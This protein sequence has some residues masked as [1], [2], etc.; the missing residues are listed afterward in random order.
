M[1][2]LPTT[3]QEL[4]GVQP[5][6]VLISADAYVD[7]PSFGHALIA[8]LIESQG[9]TIGII[10]QPQKDSD[11]ARLGVPKHAF[12]ISGGVVDS[13][14]N[15]YTV[16]KQ[17]RKEDDYSEGGKAGMRPDRATTVYCQTLKR[18]YSDVPVIIGGIEASLR[19]FAHYD[20]WSD[21]VMP[22]ILVDSQADLLIYGMGERP[23]LDILALL[24]KG[25]DIVSIKDVRGTAYLADNLPKHIAEGVSQGK[26]TF[27][28]TL[29]EVRQNKRQY[30][31]AFNIQNNNSDSITAKIVVQR[32]GDKYVIQNLPQLPLTEQEMDMVYALPYQRTYH[33]MYKGGVPAIEEVK[34]SLTSV[35]GCFGRCS[36]CALTFHQGRLVQRRSQQSIIQE[37]KLLTQDQQ[38]KGYIHDVGGPTANFRQPACKKQTTV[39][40][41]QDKQCIGYQPC[42]GLEVSHSEYLQLL[43]ELRAL[44]KVK[45][46][47]IRSGIRFDYVML[48]NNDDFF[49]ELVEHHVS[50]QLKVAPEHTEDKVLKLMNKPSFEVYKKFKNKFDSYSAKLGK[51]QYLVPY[52]I[53][54][55]PGCTIKDAIKVAEYL[56]SIGYMP[57]QV[58]DFYPTPASKSTCMYYTGIDPDSGEEIFVPRT[59]QQKQLQRALLQY[60]KPQNYW[61]VR[62]A[63][64]EGGRRDLIGNRP[65][66]LIRDNPPTD[67]T[68]Y[69]N[70]TSTTRPKTSTAKSAYGSNQKLT[71]KP[72]NDNNKSAYGTPNHGKTACA[73]TSD[74]SKP[75][76]STAKSAYGSKPT[77]TTNKSTGHTHKGKDT[78]QTPAN[79]QRS[80]SPFGTRP[81]K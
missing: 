10:A 39:G 60:K 20:Y 51:K 48:D 13:M 64:L 36:Y 8:R 38:F 22:S 78:R 1:S 66:C 81:K 47:F 41:C 43:R 27:C 59:K 6:F 56:H 67:T 71:S 31:R 40:A 7:H 77:L 26:V 4:N 70:S 5:D 16:A 42:K 37:A 62:Q 57:E 74:N 49:R 17:R 30:V 63:L 12:L 79:S 35:R 15:N 68:T 54:S 3:K 75:S 9:F 33:P 53:S 45:K 76:N 73:K 58:Q 29:A 24:D 65:N 14:V 19:R 44:D 21:T 28:P 52:L 11:Y 80:K 46:V 55:H 34:F 32:H 25:V 23:F 69:N 2:F 50:G 18:L 72:S 61:L